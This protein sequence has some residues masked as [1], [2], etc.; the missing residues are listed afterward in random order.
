[1]FW[2]CNEDGYQISTS[3][4][5]CPK[6]TAIFLSSTSASHNIAESVCVRFMLSAACTR[7]NTSEVSFP[8]WHKNKP[9]ECAFLLIDSRTVMGR[10]V[11]VGEAPLKSRI[12]IDKRAQSFTMTSDELFAVASIFVGASVSRNPIDLSRKHKV[13]AIQSIG[14]AFAAEETRCCCQSFLFR[15]FISLRTASL[16]P[17]GFSARLFS[18]RENCKQKSTFLCCCFCRRFGYRWFGAGEHS[19]GANEERQHWKWDSALSPKNLLQ[20][21]DF[22]LRLCVYGFSDSPKKIPLN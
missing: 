7:T 3:Q 13:R 12:N 9:P 19:S 20:F 18:R 10:K 11:G 5:Q 22:W 14:I 16:S 21:I 4:C 1:M 15:E 8:F 6:R 2:K 17:H